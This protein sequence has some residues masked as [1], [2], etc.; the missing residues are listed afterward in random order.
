MDDRRI[1]HRARDVA[2]VGEIVRIPVQDAELQ[3]T[4]HAAACTS[5]NAALWREAMA[6]EYETL[7]A[8]GAIR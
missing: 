5:Q 6:D 8:A 3:S 4:S 2:D 7:Q 1:D